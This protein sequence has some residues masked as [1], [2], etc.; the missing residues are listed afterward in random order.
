MGR[1]ALLYRPCA[2]RCVFALG[3][4]S[5]RLS[6]GL[7]L[8]PPDPPLFILFCIRSR[9]RSVR[10]SSDKSLDH[11]GRVASSAEEGSREGDVLERLIIEPG[12]SDRSRA[13][14]ISESVGD[15]RGPVHPSGHPE[16]VVREK[17][18][19]LEPVVGVGPFA[20]GRDVRI[21]GQTQSTSDL[22]P[23]RSPGRGSE[24]PYLRSAGGTT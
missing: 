12:C 17:L 1:R 22:G 3:L 24:G 6:F 23:E 18:L 7:S 16:L 2:T 20:G 4:F 5:L 8:P 11:D 21:V 9:K 19:L 13:S 15:V 14:R 10:A